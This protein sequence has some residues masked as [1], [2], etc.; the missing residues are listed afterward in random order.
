[1]RMKG[2][3]DKKYINERRC[4][5]KGTCEEQASINIVPCAVGRENSPA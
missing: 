1:M 4:R 5:K 3:R 2:N